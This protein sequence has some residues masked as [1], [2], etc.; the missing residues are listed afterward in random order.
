[1]WFQREVS[2]VKYMEL[3]DLRWGGVKVMLGMINLKCL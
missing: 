2:Q 3:S 1:M